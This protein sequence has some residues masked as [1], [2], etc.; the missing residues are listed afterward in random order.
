[1]PQKYE[2][3]KK[4]NCAPHVHYMFGTCA[5]HVRHMCAH[6]ARFSPENWDYGQI[7]GEIEI[8]F[9]YPLLFHSSAFFKTKL[10]PC[11]RVPLTDLLLLQECY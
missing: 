9:N 1:M 8:S 11:V 10:F 7:K 3:Q 6:F 2:E 5:L 4:I